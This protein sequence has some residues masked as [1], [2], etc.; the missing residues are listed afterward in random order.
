MGDFLFERRD[1]KLD[2]AAH[3]AGS[4]TL[5][6]IHRKRLQQSCGFLGRQHSD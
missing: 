2:L 4:T 5:L 6:A 1:R 3:A